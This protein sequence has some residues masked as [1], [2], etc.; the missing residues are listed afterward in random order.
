[1]QGSDR[2]LALLRHR[3]KTPKG[4]L[5]PSVTQITGMLDIDSK[6]GRMAGAAAKIALAGGNYRAEWKEKA[7]RGTRIHNHCEHWLRGEPVDAL[8]DEPAYLDGLKLFFEE[9]DPEPLAVEQVVLSDLGYGGRFDAILLFEGKQTLVD[10]KTGR[11]YALEHC[12]QL[13][14]YRFADGMAVYNES[15]ALERLDALP[16]IERSGC[17]YLSEGEYRFVEYPADELAFTIFQGLL[18]V[19][20]SIGLLKEQLP[21]A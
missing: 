4:E 6:S 7:D 16:L 5:A 8:P 13:S 14:A 3:Y 18:D 21:D 17:L 1:M 20:Y 2:E 15:G 12:L 11:P 19:H 9:K 10:V